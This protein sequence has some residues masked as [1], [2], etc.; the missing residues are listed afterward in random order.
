MSRIDFDPEAVRQLATILA[1]TGLTEI[2]IESGDGRIRVARQ[3]QA[4][5]VSVQVPVAPS[6][7]AAPAPSVL[8]VAAVATD[9]ADHPGAVTSPMVG[10]VYLRPSLARRTTRPPARRWRQVRHCC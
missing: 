4:A 8:A 7:P 9:D 1:E 6:L 2:E 3:L 5:P 10:V